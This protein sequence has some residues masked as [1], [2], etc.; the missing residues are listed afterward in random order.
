MI[1][2]EFETIFKT[3]NSDVFAEI[4]SRREVTFQACH[5][6]CLVVQ[7]AGNCMTSLNCSSL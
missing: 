3:K 2:R 5:G 1:A 7:L 6:F 4:I